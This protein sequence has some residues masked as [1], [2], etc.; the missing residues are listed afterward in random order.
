[1]GPRNVLISGDIPGATSRFVEESYDDKVIVAWTSGAAG[2]QAPLYN[3]QDDAEGPVAIR[4]SVLMIGNIAIA[5]VSGEPNTM[6]GQ[7]ISARQRRLP[8]PQ[9]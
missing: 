3:Q 7:R 2:D 6:I 5:G 9:L 1:M 4:L 8:T